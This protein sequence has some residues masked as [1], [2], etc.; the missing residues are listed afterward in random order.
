MRTVVLA[1]VVVLGITGLTAF[2]AAALGAPSA[3]PEATAAAAF[4]GNIGRPAITSVSPNQGPTAGGARVTIKGSNFVSVTAIRFGSVKGKS[5]KVA[6]RTQ[7]QVT[8]PPGSAGPVAVRVVTKYGTSAA[9]SADHYTYD[10]DTLSA[11]QGLEPGQA[12]YASNDQYAAV[13][14]TDGNFV[15]YGTDSKVLWATGTGTPGSKI[16]MQTDGNL[17][18][19][20]PDGTALWSSS[21]APSTDDSLVMQTD[22]NLVIYSEGGIALWDYGSG[23]IGLPDSLPAGHGL[24]PGQALVSTDGDYAAAMQTDGNFV[25]YGPGGKALWASGTGTPGSVIIMQYDG[26]LVIYAPDGTALW[27]SSTAPSTDDD[28]AMQND[29]NLVIYT[30][31]GHALWDYSSGVLSTWAGPGFCASHYNQPYLGYS[32]DGVAACGQRYSGPSSNEQGPIYYNNIEFD[33]IGFQCVEYAARYFYYLTGDVP[34]AVPN[35]SWVAYDYATKYGYS[36][37]PAGANGSTSTFTSSL[38]PGQIISMWSSSDEHVAVV[39]A[40]N[41]SNGNGTIDVID[42]NASSTGLDT[43]TVT[44]G[45]MSYEGVYFDFQWTTNL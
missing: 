31:G 8:A 32:Y 29:G 21:T 39:T 14:Q 25:V 10:S 19:Y 4:P 30:Q 6:S 37:Y 17:V 43:I 38:T 28:L 3:R 13:M 41:V 40:V 23:V 45:Q 9:A 34:P 1:A 27:S 42:E 15:V 11:G 35:G 33:S 5:V 24:E 20:A 16:I 12:L 18:I 44:N 26:N 7:L 36:V 2:P 22:G